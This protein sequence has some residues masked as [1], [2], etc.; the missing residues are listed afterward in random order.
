MSRSIAGWQLPEADRQALLM[1]FPPRYEKVVAD[2][3]TLRYG[4]DSGTELPA[5]HAGVVIGEADDGAG[6]QALVVAI[7]GRSERGDGSHF[8]LTWSLAERRKAKESNDV[9]A[10]H[11]WEPVD[12]PV[13]VMLE[14]ARWKP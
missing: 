13:A 6:V 1:R 12:P 2:H 9:I 4:T 11:G 14:P 5:E 3:V 8:H 7:G 10:D